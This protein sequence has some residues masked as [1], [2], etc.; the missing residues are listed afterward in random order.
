[1]LEPLRLFVPNPAGAVRHE[2]PETSLAASRK[3]IGGAEAEI[4]VVFD[5]LDLGG[6]SDDELCACL[7]GWHAPTIKSARSR[8]SRRGLLVDSGVRRLSD[9]RSAMIVWKLHG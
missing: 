6:L 4:M 5:R 1:M 9:T 2:D 7:P 8:L 3:Q